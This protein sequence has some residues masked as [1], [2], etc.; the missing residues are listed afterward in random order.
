MEVGGEA[1]KGNER[2][3]S[4]NIFEKSTRKEWVDDR[5]KEFTKIK[6]RVL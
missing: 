2:E 5:I 3:A 4:N 1:E 6:K